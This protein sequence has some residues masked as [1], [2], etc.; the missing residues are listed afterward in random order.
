[1]LDY[2]L[3]LMLDA[4]A[5]F[6]DPSGRGRLLQEKGID[7]V[8]VLDEMRLGHSYGVGRPS[9]DFAGAPLLELEFQNEG[10][11]IYRVTA[12]GD[13]PDTEFQNLAG[14]RCE[15]DPIIV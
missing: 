7:Y 14:Y 11:R 6:K 3:D 10:A 4:R 8:V 13:P 12:A 2:S 5:F 1:M 9:P 15:S